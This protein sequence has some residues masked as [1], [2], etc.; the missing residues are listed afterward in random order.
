MV[1]AK[2]MKREQTQVDMILAALQSGARITHLDAIH[3]FGCSRLAARIS[4]IRKLGHDVKTR[5][6]ATSAGAHIAE[7]W[8]EPPSEP[9]GRLNL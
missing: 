4:D 5:M 3:R 6:V 7:Y 1:R 8:L 9:Q 2:Y